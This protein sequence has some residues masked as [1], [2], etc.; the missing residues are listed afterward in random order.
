MSILFSHV[1]EDHLCLS[2][3]PAS[4]IKRMALSG[5]VFGNR[6]C[7][8]EDISNEVDMIVMLLSV[9]DRVEFDCMIFFDLYV[10]RVTVS[11][12]C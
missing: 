9:Y 10:W 2:C 8:L 12:A 7:Y 11:L 3:V 1:Q 5:E 4:G 6:M